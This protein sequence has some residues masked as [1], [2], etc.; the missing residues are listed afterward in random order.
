MRRRIVL[1]LI[2][3]FALFATGAIVAS[4]Y[5]TGATEQLRQLVDLHEVE[6][7]R[8]SLVIRVQAALADLYTTNTPMARTLDGI[9]AD[10]EDL[11]SAADECASCHHRPE[12]A[13]DLAETR[14]LIEDYKTALSHYITAAAN[15]E[16]IGRI[17]LEAAGIGKQI[18]EHTAGM[19]EAASA[20][21]ALI[22]ERAISRIERVRIILL[23]TIILT[24]CLGIGVSSYLVR[25]VTRPIG[26]LVGATEIIASGDLSHRVE[27][28]KEAEFGE[29]AKH[30]NAMSA[31]LHESYAAQLL[32][33]QK[34]EALGTLSA[35]IAHEFGNSLQIIQSCL[36]RLASKADSENG[37]QPELEIIGDATQR[38]AGLARRLLTFGRKVETRLLPIDMN[39]QLRHVKTIL[40]QTLPETVEIQL[41][42]ADDIVSVRADRAEIEHVL[43]NLALN[44]RD[45]MPEGGLLRMET[46][47]VDAKNLP[48]LGDGAG[49]DGIWVLLRVS[50]TGHGMDE[51]TLG[52]IFD[53]FFT[54]KGVGVGTGLGLAT[55]YGIVKGCG[56]RVSCNSEVGRG[57]VFE[58]H[59]PGMC[60]GSLP[61]EAET[62]STRAHR[63]GVET[64]LLVDDEA[65]IIK[66]MRS[67]LEEH[68]YA[69]RTADSGE[70]AIEVF[71]ECGDEIDVV[72]LDLGMPGM[73]GR[74]CLQKLLEIDPDVRV[75]ISSGYGAPDDHEEIL[76]LGA[77]GFLAKPHQLADLLSE[78]DALL[79]T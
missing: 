2:L 55:V 67:N 39:E 74:A 78:I 73:G 36:D 4:M 10:V 72:I 12:I 56:G 77:R 53:P 69:V 41:S 60:E 61:V 9:V 25:S 28:V 50:D 16:R 11:D 3:L 40:D 52:R 58:I 44:A 62:A 20:T 70:R 34:M 13:A 66:V 38:G 46:S 18:L 57:T 43:V 63:Q 71:E 79:S 21:L 45:A 23:I 33:A 1:S 29:L 54:T 75:I 17:E 24:T 59:L 65:L 26:R 22:T 30:F 37:G 76:N 27:N 35:G 48:T 32:H 7:L 42:L 51:A 6:G 8:R 64:I 31:A 47:L 5:I 19:S 49:E 68:G 14:D 15:R